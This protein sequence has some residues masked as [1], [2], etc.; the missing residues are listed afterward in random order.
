MGDLQVNRILLK[1]LVKCFEAKYVYGVYV[2]SVAVQWSPYYT[3]IN[4]SN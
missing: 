1:T 3:K 4:N 2:L